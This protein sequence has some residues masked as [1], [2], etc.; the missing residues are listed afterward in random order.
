M[1][2][3][4]TNLIK[5]W[6]YSLKSWTKQI[7]RHQFRRR[8][9]VW[10]NQAIKKYL[11][12]C[13]I[14]LK[15]RIQCWSSSTCSAVGRSTRLEFVDSNYISSAFRI[16]FPHHTCTCSSNWG[17]SSMLLT[18]SSNLQV[19]NSPKWDSIPWILVQ[20]KRKRLLISW[21]H[22]SPLGK[23][24]WLPLLEIST[25]WGEGKIAKSRM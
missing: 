12:G 18:A 15:S 16:L 13:K 2:P 7:S 5:I 21:Q 6:V 17:G 14:Q 24:I 10:L 9:L 1:C 8:A 20:A 22:L 19:C 3:A 4:N 11:G 25:I 23:S